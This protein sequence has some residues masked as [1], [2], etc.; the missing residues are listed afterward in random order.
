MKCNMAVHW[1]KYGMQIV[2]IAYPDPQDIHL[3]TKIKSIATF[4][5]EIIAY[6]DFI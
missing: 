6:I 4:D 3:D 2:L 5:L 1:Y